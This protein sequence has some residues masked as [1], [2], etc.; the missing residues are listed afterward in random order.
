MSAAQD[1]EADRII[2]SWDADAFT[3][4]RVVEQF[5]RDRGDTKTADY[6]HDLLRQF[7]VHHIDGNRNNNA[8][9]NCR[10]VWV[11]RNSRGKR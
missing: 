5:Y 1:R 2:A 11:D 10:I 8:P 6:M 4:L 9:Q 7:A 3:S